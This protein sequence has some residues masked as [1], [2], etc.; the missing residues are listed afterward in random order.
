[1]AGLL[2]SPS[3]GGK[4]LLDFLTTDEGSRLGLTLLASASPQ[5]R[6][7]G[8]LLSQQD[9]MRENAMRKQMFDAQIDDRNMRNQSAKAQQEAAARKQQ[10][11]S[12]LWSGGTPALAPLMGDAASGILPSQGAPATQGRLDV[13]A[14]LQAGYTPDEIAKLDSLRNIGLDEVAR[15]MTGMQNGRE[16]AQQFD[17]FGRPVGQG[18]EQFKA[19][20]MLNQGD[21]TVALDPI[22]LQQRQSFAMGMSPEARASNALGWA[23]N[24]LSRQ[25]LAMYAQQGANTG[26]VKLPPGYRWTQDMQGME[27]IPGGPADIKAGEAGAKADLRKQSAM[28]AAQ[29]VRDTVREAKD[30]TGWS[31][32]GVGALGRTLPATDALALSSKLET[33][34]ANL[35]FDRLQQMRDQSPTGGALGSVAV[36]ELNALQSTV[37]SLDQRQSPAQLKAALDKIDKHYS[38]WQAIMD[39]RDPRKNAQSA[40]GKV[41]DAPADIQ[42]LLNKY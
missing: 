28:D 10:A 12:S 8:D 2:D 6:G 15:T 4:G 22:S 32:A 19:P 14:A 40:S 24:S 33:I 3:Q 36:Q 30:L 27:A 38:N 13:Q 26:G 42:Q 16:V 31:T 21:K 17:K 23:N 37:A 25:R 1:M 7:L 18:M 39:G 35:G 11:L 5:L 20:I 41:T 29:R 34:K 9:R